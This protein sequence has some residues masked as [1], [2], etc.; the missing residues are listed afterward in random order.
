MPTDTPPSVSTGHALHALHKLNAH[1]CA[2]GI[3][4][5]EPY[6]HFTIVRGVMADRKYVSTFGQV[7]DHE[8]PK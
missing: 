2:W 7:V 5:V 6:D 3:L 1:G 4:K 8:K